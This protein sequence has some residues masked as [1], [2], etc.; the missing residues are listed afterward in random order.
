[1][2][3][4]YVYDNGEEHEFGSSEQV[5]VFV[6]VVDFLFQH[7]ELLDHISLPYAP[8]E[9]KAMINEAP[10]NS[11]SSEMSSYKPIQDEVYLNTNY[12]KE[13][14]RS[15]LTELADICDLDVIFIGW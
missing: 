13:E 6:E 9:N 5:D 11:D 10:I 14:K 15:G 7:H 12:N 3:Q 8:G 4:V 1:M 2:Y